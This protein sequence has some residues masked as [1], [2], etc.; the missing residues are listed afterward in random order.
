[1]LGLGWAVEVASID[2]VSA[3][4]R[5]ANAALRETAEDLRRLLTEIIS[6]LQE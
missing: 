1:M 3:M 5:T 4:Q 6:D 2:P